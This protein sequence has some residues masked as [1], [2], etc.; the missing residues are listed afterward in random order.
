MG[1]GGVG[2]HAQG[3]DDEVGRDGRAVV[4]RGDAVGPGGD[5]ALGA[6]T[7]ARLAEGV[8]GPGGHLGVKHGGE[9]VPRLFHEGDGQAAVGQVLGGLHADGPAADDEGGL[10]AAHGGDEAVHVRQGVEG[11][12][13]VVGQ[14]GNGDAD[15]RRARGEEEAVVGEGLSGAVGVAHGDGLGGAIDS[16]GLAGGAHVDVE[17]LAEAFG[18]HHQQVV[19]V[20]D[21]AAH[22]VRQAAV[23]VG[24]GGP[25]LDERDLGKLVEPSQARRRA[26]PCGHAANNDNLH[27]ASSLR[28]SMVVPSDETIST[29]EAARMIAV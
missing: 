21:D 3:H 11:E 14:A 18:G 9:D 6:E 5:S 24:D 16:R 13:A 27:C 4:E 10:G 26:C 23:G 29:R 22:V 19:A 7:D 25:L 12:D 8:L 15:G 17:A 1:E 20:G 28:F 2:T